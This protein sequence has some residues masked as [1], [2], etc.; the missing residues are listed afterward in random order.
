MLR[1]IKPKL[2]EH[3]HKVL[4][5]SGSS[6][7]K[8]YDTAKIHKVSES[9]SIDQLPIRPLVSILNTAT[10]QLAKHLAKVLS[11][12]RESEYTIKSTSHFMEIIKHKIVP[13]RFQMVSFNVRSLFP[14]VPLETTLEIILR[15]ICTNIIMN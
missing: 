12:L 13:E 1:K 3:K 4:Y 2:S 6:P 15:R 8:F 7:G 14:N 11:L 5:P 9:G 10:Y